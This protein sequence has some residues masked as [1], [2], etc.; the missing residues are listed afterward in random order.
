MYNYTTENI[1]KKRVAIYCRVSTDDQVQNGNWLDMQKQAL[2]DYIKNNNHKYELNKKNIYIEEW[3]SWA[4]KDRE[5]RPVLYKM[6]DWAQNEEF[7]IVLVWKID[8][9]FRNNLYLLEWIEILDKLWI[10][11]I[12]ITQIYDTTWPMWKLMLQIMW[13]MAEMERSNILERTSNW[14]LASMRKWKWW[15]GK[16]PYWYRKGEDWLLK[17]DKEEWENIQMMFNILINEKLSLTKLVNKVNSFWI[18]TQA[19]SGVLWKTRAQ[20]KHSNFWNRWVVHKLVRNEMYTWIM[21]QNRYTA[22]KM[23]GRRIEK[24]KEEWI[25]WECPIIISKEQY[26]QAQEQLKYNRV[27]SPR[28]KKYAMEY[29][30]STLLYDKETGFKYSWYRSAKWTRNY[31]LVIDKTKS[32]DFVPKKWISWNKIEWVVWNKIRE[33][34]INPELLIKELEKLSYSNSDEEIKEQIVKLNSRIKDLNTTSSKLIELMANVWTTDA[35]NVQESI[36]VN[37]DK[38]EEHEWEIKKLET[39]IVSDEL[40]KKQLRDLKTLSKRLMK[41]MKDD[42]V[43]YETKT[44]LCRLLI[45]KVE[46][47]GEY[48]E[49]TMIVPD[50]DKREMWS[51]RKELVNDFFDDKQDFINITNINNK[52][53]TLENKISGVELCLAN[54]ISDRNRTYANQGSQPC[55][56]P[57]SYGDL[58]SMNI[59]LI[60]NILQHFLKLCYNIFAMYIIWTEVYYDTFRWCYRNF[61]SY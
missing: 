35:M 50:L 1:N 41:Y 18:R 14:V 15:R 26:N 5:K 40:K 7:D 45:E 10:W 60:Y 4:Y 42:K 57:L 33:V 19:Y 52:K 49:I 44:Y 16:P 51:P 12:S 11:F 25:E 30:L 48:V 55:A 2:L 24:P 9:F 20:T 22:D 43:S 54:G 61:K 27:Y 39:K 13:W 8:R 34:L 23:N 36:N 29:M 47:E 53:T 37:R 58:L 46:L 59:V 56:L 3:K 32:K 31:R 28:N 6:Y 21:I 38:I 17:I